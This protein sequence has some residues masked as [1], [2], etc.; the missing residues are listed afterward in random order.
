M[1]R[2][3][4]NKLTLS[5]AAKVLKGWT[6]EADLL[7]GIRATP[8][9][10]R[11]LITRAGSV[12]LT[13]FLDDKL[14]GCVHLEKRGDSCYLG[15]LSVDVE[16]QNSGLGRIIIDESED[17]ARREF[18]SINMDMKVI[19]QRKELIEYYIRRGYRLTGKKELFASGKNIGDI[20]V[21][22]LYFEHLTKEL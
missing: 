20:K 17:Y 8:E 12:M 18:G 5:I 15:M 13:V 19:G 10:I 7:G 21:D 3:L 1:L 22:G 16:F 9:I 11:G 14:T 2:S 4:R 6:T